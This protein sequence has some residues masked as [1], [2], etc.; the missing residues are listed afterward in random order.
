MTTF[1]PEVAESGSPT[2]GATGPCVNDAVG[3][4]GLLI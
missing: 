1:T 4:G 2:M 3:G